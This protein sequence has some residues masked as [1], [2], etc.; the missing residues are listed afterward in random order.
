MSHKTKKRMKPNKANP[1]MAS[2][3]RAIAG[4]E[5]SAGAEVT[6]VPGRVDEPDGPREN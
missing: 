6:E 1:C 4:G 2:S 5:G 3:S